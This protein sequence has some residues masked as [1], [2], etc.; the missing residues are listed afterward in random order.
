MQG[1]SKH[2]Q[3]NTTELINAETTTNEVSTNQ[4]R[5]KQKQSLRKQTKQ[6]NNH[7]TLSEL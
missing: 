1:K 2:N 7:C 3:T 6:A 4:H 5:H